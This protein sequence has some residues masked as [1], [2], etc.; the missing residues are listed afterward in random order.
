MSAPSGESLEIQLERTE[1]GFAGEA[2]ATAAG[3][4]AAGIEGDGPHSYTLMCLTSLAD[5]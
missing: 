1:S 3:T 5:P 2:P 4:Y